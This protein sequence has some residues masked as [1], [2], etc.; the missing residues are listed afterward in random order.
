MQPLSEEQ[1]RHQY[2]KLTDFVENGALCLHWVG[3]DGTILWANKSELHSLGYSP[4]DYVGQHIAQ[5]HAEEDVINDILCRLTANETLHNYEAKMVCKDGSIKHVLIDSSVYRDENGQFIHTRCFTR[6]NTARKL[7][8]EALKQKTHQLEQ[9]LQALQQTQLQLEQTNKDLEFRVEER[10]NE[11]QQAK[12]LADSANKAKSEFLANMS[13]ELRTPLN[14][15][16]G[17]AQILLRDK[18][19]NPKQKDGVSIIHQCGSHLLTLINDIL[20]LSKIEARK[21]EFFSKNF[22]VESFLTSIVEMCRI[23]AEQKEIHFTYEVLNRLPKAVFADEKR[24]RQVLINLLGNAIKFTDKGGV[25]FKVGVVVESPQSDRQASA[26]TTNSSAIK[27]RFQVEDTG[28]GMTSEQVEKIFMPFE[29]VGDQERMAEGTGLG[30]AISLQIVQMMGSEIKVESMPGQGSKFWFDVE[31]TESDEWV[32]SNNGNPASLVVG[33]EGEKCKVLIVDDRWENR[34]VIVNLLEPLGFEL[35]EA[36]N[37]QEG[38]D[39]ALEWQPDLVLTDLVMPVLGGLEMTQKLR[40]LPQFQNTAIIASSA[41]VFNFDRQQSQQAGC[42]DFLPKPVQSDELLEQ[43]RQ[44]LDLTWIYEVNHQ[45]AQPS[46]KASAV[47][48]LI[49]PPAEELEA[50]YAA[51]RIGDIDSVEQEAQRL[52]QLNVQYQPF[53]QQLLQFA[54]AMDDEAIL[55]FVKQQVEPAT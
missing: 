34:S 55:K 35:M 39:K 31:L 12:E 42:N 6:D 43:F 28:V 49:A 44:H 4:E 47:S 32:E 24:L 37:G 3:P 25:T 2:D 5:F 8:E 54:Q 16:L 11:L 21:L 10:T 38:Y 33:Y 22:H 9:T 13:H 52:A 1:L 26:T 23:K 45:Q 19:A 20:D 48:A 53:A 40:S 50:L 27:I 15:I 51:A 17:Y 7:A 14:G 29:Q 41:S 46:V 30:L 18:A 36:V